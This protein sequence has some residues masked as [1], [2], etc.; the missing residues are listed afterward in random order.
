MSDLHNPFL[1]N[2]YRQIFTYIYIYIKA[3]KSDLTSVE[4]R[5]LKARAGSS[6]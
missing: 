2:V 4:A 3:A 1:Y 6:R 5:T